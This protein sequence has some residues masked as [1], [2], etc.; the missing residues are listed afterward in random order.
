[1]N[2]EIWIPLLTG[3][4]TG[5]GAGALGAYWNHRRMVRN[6]E[7]TLAATLREQVDRASGEIIA[8]YREEFERVGQAY[9]RV[10]NQ[11]DEAL[12]KYDEAVQEIRAVY[13]QLAD[14]QE[15][16]T[17]L[18]SRLAVS[19]AEEK[20]KEAVIVKLQ[21]VV[22]DL[23]VKLARCTAHDDPHVIT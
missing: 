17:T 10:A 14:A 16:I 19:E 23:K 1:M 20:R 22:D 2:I 11:R 21:A 6:D 15:K 8:R 18:K 5:G 13:A 9:D 4:L 12:A 7:A 3:L